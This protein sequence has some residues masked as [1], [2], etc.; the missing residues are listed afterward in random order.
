[1]RFFTWALAFSNALN[2][3]AYAAKRPGQDLRVR[4]YA[5]A[6]KNVTV[7]TVP[8]RFIVEF[9]EVMPEENSFVFPSRYTDLGIDF[10]GSG[11][12]HCY[13]RA[14]GFGR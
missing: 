8:R 5:A 4:D 10:S 3:L 13:C 9:A 12:R 14:D 11:H 7:N 1:M 6:D 2:G